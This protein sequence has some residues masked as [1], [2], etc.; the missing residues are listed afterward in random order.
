MWCL[1]NGKCMFTQPVL[2]MNSNNLKSKESDTKED[3]LLIVHATLCK[4]L[5][6]V[7]IVT[8]DHN[9]VLHTLETLKRCKQ[10]K[11]LTGIIL[12]IVEFSFINTELCTVTFSL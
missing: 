6:M 8:Y 7:A 10:V 3:N 4:T 9:I 11:R 5:Q 12:T 1:N 2:H